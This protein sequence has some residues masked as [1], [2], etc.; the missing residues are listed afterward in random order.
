MS[1]KAWW[2]R[3][4]GPLGGCMRGGRVREKGGSEGAVTGDCCR[5]VE[6]RV[7]LVCWRCRCRWVELLEAERGVEGSRS[8]T[9]PPLLLPPARSAAASTTPPVPPSL[10]PPLLVP[11]LLVVEARE[12]GGKKERR[13]E[14]KRKRRKRRRRRKKRKRKKRKKRRRKRKKRRKRKRRRKK[15]KKRE[16]RRVERGMSGALG[17]RLPERRV[18]REPCALPVC[19]RSWSRVARDGTESRH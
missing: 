3:R 15:R 2:W 10:V 18:L 13:E 17:R 16:K 5:G 9:L 19:G 11:P 8:C 7:V 4:A 14:E 12:R 1:R 6:E